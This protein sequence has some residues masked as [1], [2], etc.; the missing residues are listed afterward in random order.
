MDCSQYTL[1]RQNDYIVHETAV[2]M[3]GAAT[4]SSPEKHM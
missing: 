1:F 2:R 4:N 3:D